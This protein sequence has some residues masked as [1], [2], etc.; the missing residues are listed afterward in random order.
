LNAIRQFLTHPKVVNAGELESAPYVVGFVGEHIAGGAGDGIYVRAIE[1]TDQGGFMVFRSGKAYRDGATGEILGY[2]ALY[3]AEAALQATGDPATLQLTQTE[4]EVIIGDRIMPIEM[5][6]MQMN[7]QPHAPK[8]QIRGQII[9]V[10]D[11]VT[12]IGQYQ[13]V[14]IDRGFAD[15]VETGHVLDILRRS[16]YERDIVTS[17]FGE[18]VALPEEKEG[19]LMIFQPFERVSFGLIM[20][21]TRAIHLSDVVQT[22]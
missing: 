20:N 11:G 17:G 16:R 19:V 18:M 7:Y 1:H 13:I 2:E 4:R 5:E 10:V 22:P 8:R 15:G 12:E 21:A 9:S 6:K 14:V 3:V